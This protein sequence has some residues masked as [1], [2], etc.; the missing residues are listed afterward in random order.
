M[1]SA[2][3]SEVRAAGLGPEVIELDISRLVAWCREQKRPIDSATRAAFTAQM[4]RSKCEDPH[5]SGGV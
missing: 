3:L 1:A 5:S 4:L 2:S